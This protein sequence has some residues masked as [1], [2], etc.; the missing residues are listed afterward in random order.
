MS[1]FVRVSTR[2]TVYVAYDRLTLGEKT[3]LIGGARPGTGL[4]LALGGLMPRLNQISPT[5][6]SF[7]RSPLLPAENSIALH[8]FTGSQTF[9]P[10]PGGDRRISVSP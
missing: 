2:M 5:G 9:Q 1:F 3:S 7:G 4:T 8:S 10:L 6:H